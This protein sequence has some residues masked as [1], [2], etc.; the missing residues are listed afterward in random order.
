MFKKLTEEQ[1]IQLL[2]TGIDEFA[3]NGLDGSSVNVIA[4]KAGI[5][6][7]V[8]YKYY[9]DK[10]HFFL[11]CVQRSLEALD[12]ILQEQIA[13][14]EKPLA[15]AKQLISTL[16]KY[17]RE[18]S[19]YI[20]MYHLITTGNNK[21]YTAKLAKEIESRSAAVYT[22]FIEE[23]QGKGLIRKD[24]TPSLF[25]FF[26]DNLLMM[27]HFSYCNDYYKERF[28]IFCGSRVMNDDSL[29]A[30]ELVKFLESAFTFESKDI[31]HVI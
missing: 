15:H 14:S 9:T 25:A 16:Q 28:K 26:F 10:E 30:E 20:N 13:S 12:S 21:I 6:I 1:Q 7:G 29:V 17:S 3:R 19:S 2:E 4:E 11:A 23:A 31:I 5:S 8:L 27:L 18:H 24:I 22:H